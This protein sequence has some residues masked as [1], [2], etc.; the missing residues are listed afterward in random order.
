MFKQK[1]CAKNPRR[2]KVIFLQQAKVQLLI[3]VVESDG[4][5]TS[6]QTTVI[7]TLGACFTPVNSDQRPF[8]AISKSL[9]RHG[10]TYGTLFSA[11]AEI[12]CAPE[13]ERRA[14]H[15]NLLDKYWLGVSQLAAA[16][17]PSLVSLKTWSAR[18]FKY[19][20][21]AISQ[22]L[23]FLRQSWSS[24]AQGERKKILSN[25]A[26]LS[27]SLACRQIII[28]GCAPCMQC[29]PTQNILAITVITT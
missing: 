4:N 23:H 15:S 19:W 16:E 6:P 14:P 13:W 11:L 12:Q 27:L 22:T 8:S 7:T 25:F 20:S 18:S 10:P 24:S 9:S 3:G 2:E 1:P 26:C 21:H 17:A 28:D 5:F 29:F